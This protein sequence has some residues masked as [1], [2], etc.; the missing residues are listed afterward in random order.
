MRERLEA[1]ERSNDL[2]RSANALFQSS[3]DWFMDRIADLE[4]QLADAKGLIEEMIVYHEQDHLGCA[5]E[6]CPAARWC[7]KARGFVQ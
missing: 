4:K 3:N 1:L 5:A 2:L 7:A 6:N